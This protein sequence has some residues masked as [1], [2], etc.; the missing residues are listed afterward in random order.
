MIDPKTKSEVK[1]EEPKEVY[2]P[3][4]IEDLLELLNDTEHYPW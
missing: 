2:G 4:P 1:Q 3:S